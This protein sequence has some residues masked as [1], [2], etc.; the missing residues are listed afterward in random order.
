MKTI[1]EIWRPIKGYDGV[2]EISNLGHIRKGTTMLSPWSQYGYSIV[3]LW[4]NGKCKKNRVHRLVA[5]A[6]IPNPNNLPSINHID[7]NKTNNI[8]SNL[9]WCSVGYNNSYGNRTQKMLSTYKMK[10]TSNCEREVEQHSLSGE[11][12]AVYKSLS[13]ASR[14]T[15]LS[16]GNLSS[17]CN[18]KS[19]RNTL[20]GYLW[21]FRKAMEE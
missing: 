14:I 20:G 13:E 19:H 5:E 15:G 17:V 16:I 10:N 12:L 3:G 7:E 2:Y 11:L 21:N 6:F 18:K 8:V 9:E 4:K 1:E